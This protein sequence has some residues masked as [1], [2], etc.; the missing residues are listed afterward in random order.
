MSRR[1]PNAAEL[2]PSISEQAR[3]GLVGM[4]RGKEGE[5][6]PLG[7]FRRLRKWPNG[8]R[9]QPRASRDRKHQKPPLGQKWSIGD[10]S[11]LK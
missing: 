5:E 7:S 9:G 10:S 3:S 6:P 2:L 11:R 8:G 4:G 1:V